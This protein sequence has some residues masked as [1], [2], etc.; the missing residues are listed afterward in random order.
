MNPGFVVAT[1]AFAVVVVASFARVISVDLL[2]EIVIV[3]VI[4]ARAASRADQ[5]NQTVDQASR[6]ET[7]R[8]VQSIER[9]PETY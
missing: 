4:D 3:P 8:L 5:I 2:V 7:S 6:C 9:S 1:F